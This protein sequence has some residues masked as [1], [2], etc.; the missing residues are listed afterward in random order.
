MTSWTMGAS[1]KHSDQPSY[2]TA[3]IVQG[4]GKRK[5]YAGSWVETLNKA[6]YSCAGIDNRG[7]GRSGGLFGYV[8]D[9]TDWVNDLVSC[10][11]QHGTA[12]HSTAHH[13]PAGPAAAVPRP[14]S[15]VLLS[16]SPNHQGLAEVA[17]KE[18]VMCRRQQRC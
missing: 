5:T 18:G 10:T 8:N 12:Q 1:K 9:H 6:G 13:S 4:I 7:C 14:D 17:M 3:V 2:I 16:C 15:L 11:A